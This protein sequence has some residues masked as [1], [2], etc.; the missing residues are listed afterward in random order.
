MPRD[1]LNDRPRNVV[2]DLDQAFHEEIEVDS[3]ERWIQ[4]AVSPLMLDTRPDSFD[5]VKVGS[6]NRQEKKQGPPSF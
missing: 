2:A 6:R 4:E 3:S 5:R 1:V